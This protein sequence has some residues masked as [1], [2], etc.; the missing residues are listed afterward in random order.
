[1]ISAPGVQCHAARRT[2]IDNRSLGLEELAQPLRALRM[3]Q[4]GERLCLDLADSLTCDAELAAHFL[5]RLRLTPV[6][7]EP[8]SDDLLL[9]LGQ[10]SE[11]LTDRL[12][13]HRPGGGVGGTVD[14]VVLDEVAEVR[15]VLLT[16]R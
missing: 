11:H 16:D 8:Q 15:L 14:C 12:G 1:M 3:A 10:F 9:A 13:Q 2:A 5:E 4:L 6:E 7:A